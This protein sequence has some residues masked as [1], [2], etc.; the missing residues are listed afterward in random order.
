MNTELLHSNTLTIGSR[1]I[2]KITGKTHKNV[3]ADCDKLNEKYRDM[4]MAEISA[5]NYK[6]EN[7]R[8]YRE[9][10][11]NRMQTFDL[12][13]GYD[14]ELRIKVNR[15]WEE[16]EKQ[17]E[18]FQIP[19]SFSEAL[20]L[21]SKQAQQIEEQQKA[22]SEA[23]PNVLFADS[24]SASKTS[25]L[26]WELAKILKQNGV[27]IGQNRLFEYLRQNGYLIARNG[28]DFNMPTQKAMQLGIFE[29]K[30]TS[31]T[32]SDGH[33]SVNK[34]PKITGKGQ[35]YFINKFLQKNTAWLL[36]ENTKN[37]LTI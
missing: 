35:M 17:K 26:V 21:A 5:M 34:T 28:S 19:Q 4:F 6:A 37:T 14:L 12:V 36:A 30:E 2:A 33:I 23:Q 8:Y 9:Y 10:K 11:L 20:Q 16:L 18:T 25:I 3:L 31:I 22:L 32:Y 7:G 29:I 13:T 1:E 15:R 27:E 24:V